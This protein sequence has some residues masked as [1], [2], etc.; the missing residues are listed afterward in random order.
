MVKIDQATTNLLNRVGED[1]N[2]DTSDLYDDADSSL[3]S[4][5]GMMDSLGMSGY[6]SSQMTNDYCGM[7]GGQPAT[8][9]DVNKPGGK[10]GLGGYNRFQGISIDG[11]SPF[12]VGSDAVADFMQ[13]SATACVKPQMSI[14]NTPVPPMGGG[15]GMTGGGSIDY[16][17]GDS[18]M[19][20][21]IEG[22]EGKID[23][24]KSAF[25]KSLVDV[26]KKLKANGYSDEDVGRLVSMIEKR[27]EALGTEDAGEIELPAGGDVTE[28]E[29]KLAEL[30]H[31]L[32]TLVAQAENLGTLVS[33]ENGIP[34]R[35]LPKNAT[36]EQQTAHKKNWV[37]NFGEWQAHTIDGMDAD[38]AKAYV[39]EVAFEPEAGTVGEPTT[40]TVKLARD[41][42]N[43]A[44]ALKRYKV[45]AADDGVGYNVS[46]VVYFD[47]AAKKWYSGVNNG[48]FANAGSEITD[49]VLP[50]SPP[51]TTSDSIEGT[52]TIP[53]K[54]ASGDAFAGVEYQEAVQI[55]GMTYH[56]YKVGSE[57]SEGMAEG[58]ILLLDPKT[59]EWSKGTLESE[60]YTKG[61]VLETQPQDFK[62]TDDRIYFTKAERTKP[63]DGLYQKPGKYLDLLA[64]PKR[65]TAFDNRTSAAKARGERVRDDLVSK[66]GDKFK[67]SL[68]DDLQPM[69]TAGPRAD[70][71]GVDITCASKDATAV[72]AGLKK[73]GGNDLNPAFDFLPKDTPVHFNGEMVSMTDDP[74]AM[75]TKQVDS[76]PI[77]IK[78]EDGDAKMDG[79]QNSEMT[80]ALKNAETKDAVRKAVVA[81]I[82]NSVDK[83]D[84]GTAKNASDIDLGAFAIP[85]GIVTEREL[86]TIIDRAVR[87][88]GINASNVKYE[89]AN[90][91]S[92]FKAPPPP[93]DQILSEPY[94]VAGLEVDMMLPAATKKAF[95]D[96][97]E[98]I[99]AK[100][101]ERAK[102]M[103]KDKA[104][105]NMSKP[106]CYAAALVEE[107]TAWAYAHTEDWEST[108]EGNGSREVLSL[109]DNLSSTTPRG[110]CT[111]KTGFLYAL[112]KHAQSEEFSVALKDATFGFVD[113][114]TDFDGKS[115]GE[116]EE[117]GHV[118]LQSTIG[119]KTIQSDIS[120]PETSRLFWK[121]D[122]VTP[123]HKHVETQ[124][125]T[126]HVGSLLMNKSLEMQQAGEDLAHAAEVIRVADQ[127]LKANV[128]DVLRRRRSGTEEDPSNPFSQATAG[129]ERGDIGSSPEVPENR[130]ATVGVSAQADSAA[131]EEVPVASSSAVSDQPEQTAAPVQPGG[132]SAPV[133]RT[134][135]ET[136]APQPNNQVA[137]GPAPVVVAGVPAS[138]PAAGTAQ[139]SGPE[140]IPDNNTAPA[141]AAGVGVGVGVG[142]TGVAQGT[143]A[144]QE[145]TAPPQTFTTATTGDISAMTLTDEA[146]AAIDVEALKAEALSVWRGRVSY[147]EK[148]AGAKPLTDD[149]KSRMYQKTVADV[150]AK[151]VQ[152]LSSADMSANEKARFAHAAMKKFKNGD[153]DLMGK[154]VLGFAV[155][156]DGDY[157]CAT[158]QLPAS[159]AATIVRG[160]SIPPNDKYVID[161]HKPKV[162]TAGRTTLTELTFKMNADH[163][164][165]MT[166]AKANAAMVSGGASGSSAEGK[167]AK[168]KDGAEASAAKAPAIPEN[169]SRP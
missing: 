99:K 132:T 163:Y 155:K 133:D 105:K 46:D 125:L 140:N 7:L 32:A 48:G 167:T 149:R 1:R 66:F 91:D 129:G 60:T 126:Q 88:Y 168:S 45:T 121:D 96:A 78:A 47:P 43:A 153:N 65:R 34:S 55:D 109:H 108:D 154:V 68:S 26:K 76:I 33:G 74:K 90:K 17:M 31:E 63:V 19:D 53:A 8:Q 20:K 134:P 127:F 150:V 58:N 165:S 13:W 158:Y 107:I 84:I 83:D 162:T 157:L 57:V 106:D 98:R 72:Y 35:N 41:K 3:G 75:V 159:L 10:L 61:D 38:D 131:A 50:E 160:R 156:E 37:R 135:E 2:S 169:G 146:S 81:Q 42:S 93:T 16:S 82:K 28:D 25:K 117:P 52:K 161:V 86:R 79:L 22:A 5:A 130:E 77:P 92:V 49:G 73:A 143:G 119:G 113:V 166:T 103:A 112:M 148:R 89:V 21:E 23:A 102:G 94:K 139:P 67:E 128:A 142:G 147:M 24:A 141:N 87:K 70:G 71:D 14:P 36:T 100:A 122:D 9:H 124:T 111:E 137:T 144:A 40:A 64:N 123:V 27:A 151:K 145:E 62:S 85:K 12:D 69:I 56:A 4:S 44:T 110:E 104:Y 97:S 18:G 136:S 59:N 164:T 51:H 6:S 80:K 39:T 29:T 115:L 120:Y 152:T 118:C 101:Q 11:K 30:E 138:N 116:G 95:A 114:K 54:P 15:E